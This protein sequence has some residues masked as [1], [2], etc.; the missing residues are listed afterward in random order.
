MYRP[1]EPQPVC[2]RCQLSSRGFCRARRR[3]LLVVRRRLCRRLVLLRCHPSHALKVPVGLLLGPPVICD[4]LVD[5]SEDE[6]VSGSSLR[7]GGIAPLSYRLH[8]FPLRPP[9][10]IHG[11][12]ITRNLHGESDVESRRLLHR[13][14]PLAGWNGRSGERHG[15]TFC[16]WATSARLHLTKSSTRLRAGPSPDD[17]DNCIEPDAA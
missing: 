13:R 12:A 10:L 7:A 9:L 11:F 2:A 15:P 8:I 14:K 5:I 16:F 6:K 3:T 1:N 17:L 4:K